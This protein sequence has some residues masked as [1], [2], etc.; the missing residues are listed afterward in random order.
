M[1][2]FNSNLGATLP[3]TGVETIVATASGGRLRQDFTSSA[4]GGT[5]EP[6]SSR[7]LGRVLT[8]TGASL[9]PGYQP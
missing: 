1:L 2:Y 5:G 9:P 7:R 4:I 6:R 3:W 8:L